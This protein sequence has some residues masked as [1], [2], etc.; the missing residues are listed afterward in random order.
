MHVVPCLAR[1]RAVEGGREISRRREMSHRW[2]KGNGGLSVL[3]GQAKVRPV[4]THLG[5]AML[6]TAVALCQIVATRRTRVIDLQ[7]GRS[8]DG[9]TK[10][11]PVMSAVG[12]LAV[13]TKVSG[14]SR[15]TVEST[16]SK[17]GRRSHRRSMGPRTLAIDIGGSG[18]KASVLGPR[19]R[20]LVEKA[21]ECLRALVHFDHL[22]I[23]GGNAR[24][25]RF[26]PDPDDTIIANEAGIRG[27]VAL[28]R[29][30]ERA[31]RGSLAGKRPTGVATGPG[32]SS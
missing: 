8:S 27:G 10:P 24:K 29:A 12:S 3:D 4:L 28:W 22:Y 19:G 5:L 31:D 11:I 14:L 23:G 16:P 21:I 7:E 32:R 15:V 17:N 26:R 18:L 6:G 20:M 13:G 2:E 25:L 9:Q 30:D 1:C